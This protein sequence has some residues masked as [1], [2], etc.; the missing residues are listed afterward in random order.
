[1]DRLSRHL[2]FFVRTKMARDPLWQKFSVILSGHDIPG[3]GEHKIMEFVRLQVRFSCFCLCLFFLSTCPMLLGNDIPEEGEPKIGVCAP[4]GVY[5]LLSSI[6]DTS[7]CWVVYMVAVPCKASGAEAAGYTRALTSNTARAGLRY[8]S[9]RCS[10]SNS[11]MC[12][13]KKHCMYTQWF[14]MRGTF[15]AEA[16]A[17]DPT[18]STACTHSLSAV[19]QTVLPAQCSQVCL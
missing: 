19:L 12:P 3:E 9:A 11:N 8:V 16:G 5:V 1:M 7:S 10:S 14:Q 18:N 4:P 17:L 6:C 15:N 2:K 13:T